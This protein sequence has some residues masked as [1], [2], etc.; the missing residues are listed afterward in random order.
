MTE[1]ERDARR[2]LNALVTA[3][4]TQMRNR[5]S[6]D[7]AAAAEQWSV[8]STADDRLNLE[9]HRVSKAVDW[10]EARGAIY[11]F[12]VMGGIESTAFQLL[13]AGVMLKEQLDQADVDKTPDRSGVRDGAASW[14]RSHAS[15]FVIGVAVTVVGGLILVA[16]LAH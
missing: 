1:T 12:R 13:N 2:I 10:L 16:I 9:I 11:V 4:N 6:F 8:G 15:E 5:H 3:V 7:Q 14:I